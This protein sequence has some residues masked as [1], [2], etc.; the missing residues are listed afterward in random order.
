MK[1][2]TGYGAGEVQT[3]DFIVSLELK[4]YNN[5]FLEISHVMPSGFSGFEEDI[6]ARIKAAASRGRVEVNARM[7]SIHS[8]VKITVDQEALAQYKAALDQIEK[9]TGCKAQF[10]FSDLAAVNGLI[11][12]TDDL[13]SE[14]LKKAVLQALDSALVQ[15]RASKQREGDA[16]LADIRR[17]LDELDASFKVVKDNAVLLEQTIRA[18]LISK[19]N[20]MLGDKGYDEGRFLQEVAVQ[21]VKYTI[22]EEICRLTAHITEAYRLIAGSEPCG[23]RLDFLT[24]EMNRE[25][26]T[27]GSKNIMV[28]ISNRVV[29]MKDC[30]ENIREQIRNIE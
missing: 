24:Q 21:L 28:E 27:I 9:A 20:E 6:D 7:K 25:I 4:S 1:S 12:E 23:K 17:L 15:F 2:M 11:T 14:A 30:L 19:F 29:V 16:T 10:S 5:R 26:N 18:S 13:D 22:N 3:D 8:G